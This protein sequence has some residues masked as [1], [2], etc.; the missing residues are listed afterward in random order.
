MRLANVAAAPACPSWVYLHRRIGL[1]D[2]PILAAETAGKENAAVAAS[3]GAPKEDGAGAKDK[4][5]GEGEQGKAKDNS[6]EQDAA[7]G[8]SGDEISDAADYDE[9]A[10]EG[11]TRRKPQSR[12][13]GRRLQRMGEET[14]KD[15]GNCEDAY[16]EKE[17]RRR[18]KNNRETPQ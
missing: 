7:K 14:Q 5:A 16:C 11:A 9:C 15:T 13:L 3:G 6:G 10:G 17:R 12:P 4:H 18:I 8:S 1:R 2:V